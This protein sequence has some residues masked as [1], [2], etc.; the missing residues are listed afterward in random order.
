MEKRERNIG[1]MTKTQGIIGVMILTNC[2]SAPHMAVNTP[3]TNIRANAADIITHD[4]RQ[5]RKYSS[6]KMK[7]IANT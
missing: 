7:R 4:F 2:E 3:P 1:T 6:N 5:N